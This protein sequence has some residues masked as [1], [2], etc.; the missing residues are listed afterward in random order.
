[1]NDK[2]LEAFEA[3]CKIEGV[4]VAKDPEPVCYS[5]AK[6][7]LAL[8][9]WQ[10]SRKQAI[11]ECIDA[12]YALP[13]PAEHWHAEYSSA[14]MQ[15]AYE[16]GLM[17]QEQ[18]ESVARMQA[19]YIAGLR[20]ALEGAISDIAKIRDLFPVPKPGDALEILWGCA[21]ARSECV[22]DYVAAHFKTVTAEINERGSGAGCLHKD[23]LIDSYK[24]AALEIPPPPHECKTEGETKAF[25]FGW[26]KAMEAKNSE[27]AALEGQPLQREPNLISKLG[28]KTK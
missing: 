15:A 4:S 14:Q 5:S 13:E 17:T 12:P 26:W 11:K 2:A 22:V 6:T 1:M 24:L 23:A 16:A 21:M 7:R 3:L 10:A 8:E 19:D 25:N 27:L 28:G 20:A 18:I 9:F